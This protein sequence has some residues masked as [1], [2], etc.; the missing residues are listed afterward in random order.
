MPHSRRFLGVN[1]VTNIEPDKGFLPVPIIRNEHWFEKFSFYQFPVLQAFVGNR[2]L[3]AEKA[4][5]SV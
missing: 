1:S 3:Q 5:E 4:L 2:K